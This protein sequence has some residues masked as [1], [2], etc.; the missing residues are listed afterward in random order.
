ME[1]KDWV[2]HHQKKLSMGVG[3]FLILMAAM[4]LF[5]D[6]TGD[7]VLKEDEAYAAK[8][9]AMEARLSGGKSPATP[10]PPSESP[11]MKVYKEKQAEHFRYTLIVLV[12][13]GAG[14]LIYGMVKK[15]EGEEI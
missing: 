14:F 5:W 2:R 9:A 11:I 4:M 3:I 8:V 15:I 12:I 6:N 1:L 13:A 10:P 7:T